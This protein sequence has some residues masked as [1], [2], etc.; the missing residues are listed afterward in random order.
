[1]LIAEWE[2]VLKSPFNAKPNKVD[3]NLSE[4]SKEFEVG[5]HVHQGSVRGSLLFIIT[6]ESLSMELGV[7]WE[8]FFA[9]DLLIIANL[10]KSCPSEGMESKGL[11][12]N[13]MQ[14]K[15]MVLISMFL[16]I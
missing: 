8:L 15:I 16:M 13:M 4:Y 6:L 1:M 5:S 12:M 2:W 9:D 3:S 14:T 10:R 11:H 7:P